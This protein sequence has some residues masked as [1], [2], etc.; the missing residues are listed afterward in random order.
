MR[1]IPTWSLAAAIL[2]VLLVAPAGAAVTVAS[3]LTHEHVARPGEQYRGTILLRNGGSTPGEVK[4]Y[5]TDYSF[6]AD[7]RDHYGQPGKLPRS[8]AGW[9]RLSRDLLTVPGGGTASVDYEVLVP[10]G[11]LDGTYWSMIM[12]E[13][14]SV[15][16]PETAPDVT[17]QISHSIRYAVQIVTQIGRE[18]GTD[19]GLAFTNPGVIE[20]DG[21][22]LFLIDVENTGKRWVRPS[23]WLELYSESG[24]PIGKFHGPASRLYPGTA[25]R[26]QMEIGQVPK[27]KYLGLVVADGTGDNL[28]GA[29]VELDIE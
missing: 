1:T 9:V 5:Q 6:G 22:R 26:F 29:N 2:T 10:A 27:G 7:G 15:G 23:L 28:F 12:V 24:Q 18:G 17:V 25:S 16:S 8:N 19:V 11:N 4:L 3:E 13:P 14:I 20:E 21:K